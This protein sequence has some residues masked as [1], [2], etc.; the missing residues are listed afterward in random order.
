[1]PYIFGVFWCVVDNLQINYFNTAYTLELIGNLSKVELKKT[2][3]FF[4]SYTMKGCSK[5]NKYSIGVKR[6]EIDFGHNE[7]E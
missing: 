4:I 6:Y 1:M 3:F 7:N 5:A 2:F